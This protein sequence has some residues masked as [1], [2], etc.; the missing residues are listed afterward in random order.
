MKTDTLEERTDSRSRST[1]SDSERLRSLNTTTFETPGMCRMILDPS[2]Y[3]KMRTTGPYY[4]K[5]PVK[6]LVKEECQRVCE[7]FDQSYESSQ[8][9]ERIPDLTC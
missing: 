3:F 1:G 4:R 2:S 9:D 6:G 8:F 7:G 5:Y